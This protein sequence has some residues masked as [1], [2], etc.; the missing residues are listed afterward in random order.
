MEVSGPFH[1]WLHT[2]LLYIPGSKFDRRQKVWYIPKCW[3]HIVT[4]VITT[5]LNNLARKEEGLM[6]GHDADDTDDWLDEAF[7]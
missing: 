2:R 6:C 3:L 5:H 7:K 4:I 1:R